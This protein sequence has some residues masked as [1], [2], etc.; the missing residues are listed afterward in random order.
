MSSSCHSKETGTIS[1]STDTQINHTDQDQINEEH[2][3]QPYIMQPLWDIPPIKRF[4]DV[5][6]TSSLMWEMMTG[7]REPFTHSWA[8]TILWLLLS[9][10][11]TPFGVG[12]I[13]PLTD[14]GTLAYAPSVI[15]G[16][17]FWAF[18]IIMYSVF[19]TLILVGIIWLS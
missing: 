1:R 13:P 3:Q 18:S 10:T 8:W 15:R 16:I 6:L 7:I 5:P 14:D 4:G 2:K 9:I 11:S 12:L 17:S 19:V